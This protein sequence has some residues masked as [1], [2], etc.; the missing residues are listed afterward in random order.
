MTIKA[1]T[2]N[3]TDLCVK[4]R[5]LIA[6]IQQYTT[7]N[8]DNDWKR[9]WVCGMLCLDNTVAVSTHRLSMFVGKCKSSINCGFQS[10]GY[11]S[12]PMSATV[13]SALA[14]TFPF[15]ARDCREVRQWTVRAKQ[16]HQPIQYVPRQ[17]TNVMN[18][19]RVFSTSH[20]RPPVTQIS[21]PLPSWTEMADGAFDVDRDG[22]GWDDPFEDVSISFS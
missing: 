11:E 17:C 12:V 3:C 7:R 5:I 21:D 6:Q 18:T 8:D 9:Q 16:A 1:N 20:R 10:L 13:A 14:R 2:A 15:F 22:F 4:F 19:P